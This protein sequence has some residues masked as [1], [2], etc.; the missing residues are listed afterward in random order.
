MI[1]ATLVY[2]G[3]RSRQA[4]VIRNLSDSGAKIEVASVAKVPRTFDL[5][6][7]RVRPQS[8]VVVW[9]AVKELGVQF[10]S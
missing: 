9:R 10:Q 1:Q 8:C 6:V 5:I 7:D 4:C 2:D 3:G